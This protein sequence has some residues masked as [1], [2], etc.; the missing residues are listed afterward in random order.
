LLEQLVPN[1]LISLLQTCW[2][3]ACCKPVANN[4]AT[5]PS[6]SCYKSVS[7]S[8][9]KQCEHILL[10]SC[11]NSIGTSLLHVCY[12]SCVFACVLE[13]FLTFQYLSRASQ[14]LNQYI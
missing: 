3:Q 12:N 10:T 4:L 5:S 7:T 2:Q 1:L 9:E 11:W 14:Y 6:T 13:N 8:W